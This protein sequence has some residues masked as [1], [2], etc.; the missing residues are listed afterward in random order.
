[1][2]MWTFKDNYTCGGD[3]NWG[4]CGGHESKL[5]IQDTADTYSYYHDGELKACGPIEELQQLGSL[6]MEAGDAGII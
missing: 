4:G 6:M 3:C 1:M 2:S 5:Q